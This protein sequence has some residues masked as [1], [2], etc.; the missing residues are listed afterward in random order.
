MIDW[1]KMKDDIARG[2]KEG[3][4][5]VARKAEEMTDE[6]QRKLKIHSLKKHIQE[7]ME[8]LGASIYNGE[9]ASPGAINHEASMTIFSKIEALSQELKEL[10]NKDAN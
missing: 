2:M 9:K 10:E 3:A 1:K 8:E 7:N 5:S 4:E 6:G